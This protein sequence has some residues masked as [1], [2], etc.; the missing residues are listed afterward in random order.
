VTDDEIAF[1]GFD[2]SAAEALC[3]V[4]SIVV[5]AIRSVVNTADKRVVMK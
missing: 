5:T 1:G 2:E 4:R 3:I